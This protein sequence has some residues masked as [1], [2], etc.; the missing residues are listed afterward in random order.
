MQV[1]A[2]D[3]RWMKRSP[4]K[5]ALLALLLEL[6][7]P[8]H[9]YR[10]ATLLARRLEPVIRVER[11]GVY[12]MLEALERLG[13]VACE[14][15]IS[16]TG[17]LQKDQRFYRP[18]EMTEPA[19]EAWMVAPVSDGAAKLEL[20]IKIAVS[21][22]SNAPA[23]LEVLRMREVSCLDRLKERETALDRAADAAPST[24]KGLAIGSVSIWTE[25][26]AQAELEWIMSTRDWMRDYAVRQETA[27]P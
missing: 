20:L 4:L 2:P 12:G 22:P 18:S 16:E 10:L 21:R 26:H 14:I 8:T 17:G 11:D 1:R 3:P 7:E 24:W 6:D 5:G 25:K 9:V 27:G 13:L 15:R 19:V 23:L